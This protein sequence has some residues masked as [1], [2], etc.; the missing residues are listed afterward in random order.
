MNE[1]EDRDTDELIDRYETQL[2][3]YQSLSTNLIDEYIISE[4]NS[5]ED[6]K[7]YRETEEL[8]FEVSLLECEL[9]KR[10]Y[11]FPNG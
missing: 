7:M 8:F 6:A 3:R 10:S 2:E 9:N 5:I 1:Y 11:D 4:L